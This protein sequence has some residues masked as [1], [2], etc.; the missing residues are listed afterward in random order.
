MPVV[1]LDAARD[2]G[3]D[4]IVLVSKPPA[5]EV[6]TRL[7]AAAR[8]TGKPVVVDFIGYPPPGR[9]LARPLRL[10][11]GLTEPAIWFH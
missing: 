10:L 9:Q 1:Q 3:T 5:P 11:E 7:L 6:A 8:A 4:V 2:P